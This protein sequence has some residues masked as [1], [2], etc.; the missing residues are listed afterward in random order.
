[1]TG[2]FGH[3]PEATPYRSREGA[4]RLRV[5]KLRPLVDS[6]AGAMRQ[7]PAAEATRFGRKA[8]IWLARGTG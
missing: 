6:L 8:G 4:C 5:T 3:A 2:D 7:Q 1:M